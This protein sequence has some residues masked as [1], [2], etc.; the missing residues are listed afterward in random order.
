MHAHKEILNSSSI[1]SD[2][3]SYCSQDPHQVKYDLTLSLKSRMISFEISQP[4]AQE[5]QELSLCFELTDKLVNFFGNFFQFCVLC[6]DFLIHL[7]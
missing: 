4:H 2:R 3:D 1:S 7:G 5:Y 6:Y